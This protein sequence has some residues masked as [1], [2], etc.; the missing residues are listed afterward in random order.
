LVSRRRKAKNAKPNGIVELLKG[1]QA[2]GRERLGQRR[3]RPG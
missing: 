1:A 2:S 3:G